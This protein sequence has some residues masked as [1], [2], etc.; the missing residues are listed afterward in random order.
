[1]K[2]NPGGYVVINFLNKFSKYCIGEDDWVGFNIES[3]YVFLGSKYLI[4]LRTIKIYD[5]VGRLKYIG[6]VN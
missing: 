2:N 5:R 3:L 6:Y 1:M 4:E